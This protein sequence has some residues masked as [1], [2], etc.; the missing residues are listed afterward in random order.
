MRK[1]ICPLCASRCNV[2]SNSEIEQKLDNI[3]TKE[4]KLVVEA[5]RQILKSEASTT[6]KIAEMG[7]V[8][9][10]CQTLRAVCFT[11]IT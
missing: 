2:L 1:P 8:A 5:M 10:L 6:L 11:E 9:D 3:K 4:R 7:F